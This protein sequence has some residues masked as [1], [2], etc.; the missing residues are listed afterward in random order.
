MSTTSLV[1]EFLVIGFFPFLALL[2]TILRVCNV[3]NLDFFQQAENWI[4]LIGVSST[5]LIYILGAIFHRIT[6]LL[7]TNSISFLLRNNLVKILIGQKEPTDQQ[8]WWRDYCFVYEEGSLNLIKRLE[9]EESLVR[10]FR[11]TIITS[12]I[13][14]GTLSWWLEGTIFNEAKFVPVITSLFISFLSLIA[15]LL[16][17]KSMRQ[18]FSLATNVIKKKKSPKSKPG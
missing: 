3:Y 12:L 14:G 17:R 1:V 13:L 8:Q 2:F 9:Y 6:Q 16:Q 4:P 18:K 10:I 15:Y 11:S 7:N 5:V